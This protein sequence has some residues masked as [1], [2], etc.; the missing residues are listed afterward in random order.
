MRWE[1][2]NAASR[3]IKR[4]LLRILLAFRDVLDPL[5]HFQEVSILCYHSISNTYLDT[6]V[7][8]EVFERHLTVLEKSGA[9]FISLEQILAWRAGTGILPRRAVALTFDDGYRDFV[10]TVLPILKEH[11]APATVF[12]VGDNAAFRA[13]LGN[14]LSLLTSEESKSFRTHPL[15]EIGYH[16]RTHANLAEISTADLE[17]ECAP[18]FG[19]RF[20]AYPGGRYSDA[21]INAVQNVGYAAAFSIKRGLVS[22]SSDLFLLPRNSVLRGMPPWM[23]RALS[24]RVIEW[25][26]QSRLPSPGKRPTTISTGPLRSM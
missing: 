10:S 1:A 17:Q 20:F 18:R 21:A 23:V 24:T 12:V 6:V 7:T 22:R 3:R 13:R 4:A 11:N 14:D 8:P 9:K 19:A 15:V 26:S 16:S 5:V 25:A 2:L